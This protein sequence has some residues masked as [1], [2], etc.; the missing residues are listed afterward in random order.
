[1][2]IR[3][4]QIDYLKG[5]WM[6]SGASTRNVLSL[7]I[8]HDS[9]YFSTDYKF[10]KIETTEVLSLPPILAQTPISILPGI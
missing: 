3:K 10:L 7:G 6:L 2:S 1:M 8:F 9:L 4:E 5:V